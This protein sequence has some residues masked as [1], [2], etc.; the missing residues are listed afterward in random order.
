FSPK[1]FYFDLTFL[2]IAM[3]IVGGVLTVTGAIVGTALITAVIQILRLAEG[4]IDLGFV[5]IPVI[6]GLTQLGLGIALL[7][8][9]WL[10]PL[11]IVGLQ[12]LGLRAKALAH[13]AAGEVPLAKP[14]SGDK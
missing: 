11:G 10:R 4:G 1:D 14:S 13:P 6:F 3:L 12:E 8:T 9:I 2:L 5:Q 7:L